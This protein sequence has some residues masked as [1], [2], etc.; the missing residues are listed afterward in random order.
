MKLGLEG[1]TALVTGGSKGIGLAIARRLAEEGCGLVLVARGEATL[2]EARREIGGSFPVTVRVRPADLSQEAATRA[3]AAEFPEVDILVNNAGAIR[4]GTLEEVD[5]A[6]WRSYW[7]LKVFGYINLTRAYYTLMKAR[8]R[9]VIVNIIGAA[10][11]Q[12]NAGYIAGS[13]G[14]AA[15]MAFTRALGA[16]SP[17]HGIRVVGVNPGPV[18]TDKKRITLRKDAQERFGDAERWPEL[19]R[20]MPFGRTIHPEEVSAMVALL[21]SDLSG[22]TSGTVVTIDGGALHRR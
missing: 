2:E 11:E 19:I 14:N 5:D 3:L 7:D 22:Y 20:F 8:Q 18:L 17:A 12:L 9:G 1:R 16:A 13:T 21:A 10:G 6:L 4:H 15:L